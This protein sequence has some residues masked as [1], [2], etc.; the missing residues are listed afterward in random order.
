TRRGGLATARSPGP[1]AGWRAV[2][3]ATARAG[4]ADSPL[5]LRALSAADLARRRQG[6]RGYRLLSLWRPA[7]AQRR[8]L[9]SAAIQRAG[10][11]LPLRMSGPSRT[12]P[13]RPAGHR[14][15]RPLARRGY[16]RAPGGTLRACRVVRRQ[17]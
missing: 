3:L 1:L 4:P 15:P 11:V 6:R 10:G 14:H 17:C 7:L 5:R 13:A 9:R 2:A 12:L 16:P 8:G